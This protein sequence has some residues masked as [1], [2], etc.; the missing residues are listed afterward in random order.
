M[1]R[2]LLQA[3]AVL[4]LLVGCLEADPPDAG[5]ECDDE[6]A[7][8]HNRM[9]IGGV[10]LSRDDCE[11]R[12][13][14]GDDPGRVCLTDSVDEC[15]GGSSCSRAEGEELGCCVHHGPSDVRF[16]NSTGFDMENVVISF[17]QLTSE[18]PLIKSTEASDFI[19]YRLIHMN[20]VPTVHATV[21]GTVFEHNAWNDVLPPAWIGRGEFEV[22][23]TLNMNSDGFTWLY[24][25]SPKALATVR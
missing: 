10:W 12:D 20:E 17:A 23:V 8:E 7:I 22:S 25:D 4:A 9:C 15:Y 5:A 24:A 18:I 16:R 2:S 6:G 13:V 19:R 3:I 11:S 14:Y 21:D 1:P